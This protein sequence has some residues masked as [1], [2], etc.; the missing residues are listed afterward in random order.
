MRI[1]VR[2]FSILR[3]QR[4]RQQE[5]VEVEDGTTAEMLY[6]QLFPPGPDGALPVLYAIDAQY[7]D[8]DTAL[9]DGCELVFVPALGGG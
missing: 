5:D 4:G 6:L 2:H 8:G 3:E 7:V 9:S 1:H